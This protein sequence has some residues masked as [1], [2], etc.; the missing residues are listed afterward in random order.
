ML[1]IGG[2]LKVLREGQGMTQVQIYKKTGINNKTLS[3]YENNVSQPDLATLKMLSQVYGVSVDYL[4]SD[5]NLDDEISYKVD[6]TERN[7][8]R[9]FRKLDPGQK[10]IFLAQLKGVVSLM[11]KRD[12]RTVITAQEES[13]LYQVISKAAVPQGVRE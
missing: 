5:C 1:K 6:P 9:L 2:R 11:G 8:L 7:L 10:E 3:G 4:L 13:T 12:S